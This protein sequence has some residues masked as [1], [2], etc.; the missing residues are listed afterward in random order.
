MT[1][2]GSSAA[3]DPRSG[4]PQRSA[5][6]LVST[7]LRAPATGERILVRAITPVASIVPDDIIEGRF[8][9][10]DPHLGA[11]FVA[12]TYTSPADLAGQGIEVTDV[13]SRRDA[14]ILR[15]LGRG[16]VGSR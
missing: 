11:S 1:S 5:R 6:L 9:R 14:C 4:R 15:E 7:G 13:A 3:H 2:P 8:A 12:G 10:Q 16:G